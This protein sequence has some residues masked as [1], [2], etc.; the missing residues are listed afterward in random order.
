MVKMDEYAKMVVDDDEE[1]Y[2]ENRDIDEM[3]AHRLDTMAGH[4]H[5]ISRELSKPDHLRIRNK[6]HRG[7]RGSSH[8]DSTNHTTA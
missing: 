5:K 8:G 7:R 2:L 1:E 4:R 6:K 3:A